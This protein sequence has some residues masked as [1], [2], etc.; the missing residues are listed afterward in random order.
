MLNWGLESVHIKFKNDFGFAQ[1]YKNTVYGF[2]SRVRNQRFHFLETF[3]IKAQKVIA[4]N[5]HC[6]HQRSTDRQDMCKID[7]IYSL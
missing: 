2:S 7:L 4:Y 6:F 3:E 5:L 1:T